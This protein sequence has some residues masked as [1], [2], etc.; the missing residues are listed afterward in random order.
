MNWSC[1]LRANERLEKNCTQWHRQTD[2]QTDMATIRP[3]RPRGPSWWKKYT[4]SYFVFHIFFIIWSLVPL[5]FDKYPPHLVYGCKV[6]S[7]EWT[8]QFTIEDW[9]TFHVMSCTVFHLLCWPKSSQSAMLGSDILKHSVVLIFWWHPCKQKYLFLGW[10]HG[11]FL[12][13]SL[14]RIEQHGLFSRGIS[15][16]KTQPRRGNPILERRSTLLL[17]L[18]LLLLRHAQV[19]SPGFWNGVDWRALVE[20]R[21]P[22]I[23]K[24][25]G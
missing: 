1:D 25:R 19:T 7:V 5:L 23:E 16:V 22:N 12:H 15:F 14:N 20:S 6:D 3:T 8:D 24:L 2:R 9:G 10:S 4:F 21:P 18:L 13:G 11:K 17:L